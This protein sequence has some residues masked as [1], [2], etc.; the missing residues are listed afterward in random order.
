[1]TNRKAGYYWVKDGLGWE[2]LRWSGCVWDGHIND[3][4]LQEVG[5]RIPE[6]DEPW[7][8]VPVEPDEAMIEA[9]LD[10]YAPF[11]DMRLAIQAAIVHAPKPED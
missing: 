7:Q 2:S 5:Q 8:C 11:G 6:P 1:M 9:A 3:G 10:A 4:D